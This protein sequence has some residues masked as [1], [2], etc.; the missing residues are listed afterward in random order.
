MV[1]IVSLAIFLLLLL[2]EKVRHQGRLRKIPIR[3]HVNGTR[4]KS[5][6][7]SL[8]AAGLRQGGVRTLAKTTGNRPVIIYPDG[9]EEI[10]ARRG[11]PRI[12]EQIA[13]VSTASRL[14]VEAIVVECMALE[15]QLQSVSEKRMLQSTIGVITNVRR[16]HL[17]VMGETADEIAEALSQTIPLKGKLVT[18]DHR[19]VALFKSKADLCNTEIYPIELPSP[20]YI[21]GSGSLSENKAIAERVCALLGIH[22]SPASFASP[23]VGYPPRN[24]IVTEVSIAGRKI[25]FIDA[26]AANDIDSTAIIE[27]IVISLGFGSCPVI[28]LL[29][30]RSDRPLRVRSFATFLGQSSLFDS[31]L[32]I[33][34]SRWIA[35][36]CLERAGFK[37]SIIALSE[38]APQALLDR[39]CALMPD[40][41]FTLFGMGNYKGPGGQLSSFLHAK[42]VSNVD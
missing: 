38:R 12:Q 1:F 3:V 21:D 34:E 41:E 13:F 7:T 24:A 20:S 25:H 33:G 37:K 10:L 35:R 42:G 27:R 4:G 28:A 36:R 18:A 19:H 9:R 26:F 5:N 2:Y 6:T 23:T 30:N 17:E 8:I 39:I 29:N 32:L 15:P 16:D 11:C 14:G 31:V 22:P 40:Q